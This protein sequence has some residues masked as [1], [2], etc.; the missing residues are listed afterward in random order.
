[1]LEARAE[2]RWGGEEK[3]QAYKANTPVLFL[4]PPTKV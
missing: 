2:E 4:R 3:F 1:M